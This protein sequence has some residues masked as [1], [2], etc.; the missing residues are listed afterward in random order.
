MKWFYDMKISIRL[1]AAF[2]VVG[3]ITAVVGYLGIVNLSKIAEGSKASFEQETMGIVYTKQAGL[4]LIEVDRS[5][6]NLLLAS[7][8]A[9][10]D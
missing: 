4:D 10:R 2:I 3:V 6:K 7:T 1:L 8:Q 9:E 5:A